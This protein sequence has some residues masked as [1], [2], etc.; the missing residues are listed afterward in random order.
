MKK[1][2][3]EQLFGD[4]TSQDLTTLTISKLDLLAVGLSPS[5]NN[6]AE[7]LLV[8]TRINSYPSNM[9]PTGDHCL[10]IHSSAS[11]YEVLL[12][13]VSK[14]VQSG[15]FDAGTKFVIGSN[16]FSYIGAIGLI[17]VYP[18]LISVSSSTHNS[19]MS[20]ISNNYSSL[21]I[22]LGFAT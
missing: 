4:N 6:T 2:T 22:A 12:N 21:P 17:L 15:Q 5:A 13:G 7:S 10:S 19:V 16:G 18:F 3:I 8:S 14:G 9:P 11:S 20:A 1:F